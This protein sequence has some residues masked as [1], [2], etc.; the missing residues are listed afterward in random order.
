M[1]YA[2]C[3]THLFYETMIV[4]DALYT[5]VYKLTHTALVYN[6]CKLH[7]Y[8]AIFSLSFQTYRKRW[9]ELRGGPTHGG[10]SLVQCKDKNS[11]VKGK[12]N[13]ETCTDIKRVRRREN[14][15][16]KINF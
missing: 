3:A 8:F 11:A 13:L 16:E 2:F 14:K 4:Y 7:L 1:V 12:I 6:A 10:Y 15:N 9:F 5:I